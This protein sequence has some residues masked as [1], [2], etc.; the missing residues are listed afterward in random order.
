[1]DLSSGVARRHEKTEVS[2]IVQAL[3]QGFELRTKRRLEAKKGKIIAGHRFGI[4]RVIT[5]VARSVVWTDGFVR[6]PKTER[7]LANGS[8]TQKFNTQGTGAKL[9][10]LDSGGGEVTVAAKVLIHSLGNSL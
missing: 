7:V 10:F 2:K 6:E 3:E 5:S 9:D 8:I 1:M 4:L